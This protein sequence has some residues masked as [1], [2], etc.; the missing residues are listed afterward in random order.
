MRSILF[1]HSSYTDA[2]SPNFALIIKINFGRVVVTCVLCSIRLLF[3]FK[4]LKYQ[5]DILS[6]CGRCSEHEHLN[7]IPIQC[8]STHREG[9]KKVKQF[10]KKLDIRRE[11]KFWL[12]ASKWLSLPFTLPYPLHTAMRM[13]LIGP[14]GKPMLCPF[15]FFPSNSICGDAA[16]KRQMLLSHVKI[17]RIEF[18]L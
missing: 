17:K 13:K 1:S 11:G 7:W 6:W 12:I 14:S 5:F 3:G 16:I 8:P 10:R 15:H 9:D 2:N 18:S 4:K